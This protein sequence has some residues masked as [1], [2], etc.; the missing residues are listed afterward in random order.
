M[1]DI[2]WIYV[3]PK[4]QFPWCVLR[5]AIPGGRI[6]TLCLE[7]DGLTGLEYAPLL[8]STE[9]PVDMAC[10]ACERELDAGTSG[11]A[12]AVAP[13]AYDDLAIAREPTADLRGPVLVGVGA[14][15]EWT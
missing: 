12:V 5:R 4:R 9:Y 14:V 15:E 13:E 3:D 10:P 6:S 2:V 1:T 8:V 7:G 11:S